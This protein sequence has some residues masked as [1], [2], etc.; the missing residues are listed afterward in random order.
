MHQ[1]NCKN[2]RHNWAINIWGGGHWPP[3]G[4][5]GGGRPRAG[6]AG[7]SMSLSADAAGR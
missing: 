6:A 5:A 4:G 2:H 7:Q 1:T 3:R